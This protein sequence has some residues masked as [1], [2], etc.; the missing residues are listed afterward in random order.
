MVIGGWKLMKQKALAKTKAAL[1]N[2]LTCRSDNA[3]ISMLGVL[4]MLFRFTALLA[5][6]WGGK[7]KM[8]WTGIFFR[9]LRPMWKK[10]FLCGTARVG[11]VPGF[12]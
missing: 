7:M 11:T 12:T 2:T 6:N 8:N 5:K 10:S 4:S 3:E 1:S 9:R